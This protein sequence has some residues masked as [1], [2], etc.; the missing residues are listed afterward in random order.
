VR[1]RRRTPRNGSDFTGGSGWI[2]AKMRMA[3]AATRARRA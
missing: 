2:A 3:A 1:T